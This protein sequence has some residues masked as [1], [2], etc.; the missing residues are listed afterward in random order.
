MSI[1]RKVAEVQVKIRRAKINKENKELKKLALQRNKALGEAERATNVA[2]AKEEKRGA[3]LKEM[4][5]KGITPKKADVRTR[6]QKMRDVNKKIAKN[7]AGIQKFMKK[8]AK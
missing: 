8:H 3:Q 6:G 4:K 7:M 2:K 1:K 5:A